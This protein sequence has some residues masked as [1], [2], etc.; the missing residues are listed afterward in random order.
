MFVPLMWERESTQ[1]THQAIIQ[2][3]VVSRG[4]G[5]APP[6]LLPWE[7]MLGDYST[8]STHFESLLKKKYFVN[9]CIFCNIAS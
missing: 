9:F 4:H 8:F 1:D 6:L 2:A 5:A 7:K 3:I